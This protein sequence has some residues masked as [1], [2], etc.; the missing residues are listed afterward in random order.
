MENVQKMHHLINHE[1]GAL[2]W[3]LEIRLNL[4][5]MIRRKNQGLGWLMSQV[6]GIG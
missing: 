2:V 1:P 4:A 5:G 6:L 3:L